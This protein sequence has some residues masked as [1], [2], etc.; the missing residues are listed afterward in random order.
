MSADITSNPKVRV[1]QHWGPHPLPGGRHR[2]QLWAPLEE[3][4]SLVLDGQELSMARSNDGWHRAEAHGRFGSTYAFELGDGRLVCDPASRQQA[5]P[6]DG[7][8][9]LTDSDS[10]GWVNASW[11]GRP[12]EEAVIYEIH[13][14]T[15][16]EKG[17]F[18][19]AV[20]KLPRLAEL[21]FTAIEVMP[22]AHFPGKRGWGYDGVLQYAPHSAYGS[23]DDFKAFIDAAH[24]LGMMVF[25][26]VVYNHFGPEGNYL[27][28]YAPGFF[29]QGASTPWGDAIAY[30]KPEVRSYFVEN[31]LYWLGEF[32][33]DGLR[34]DAI[35][36][37]E[38]CSDMHILEQIA[39][40]VRREI[41]G[42]HVH[43]MTE[44]PANG[45]D[46]MVDQPG[47]RFYRADWN[48]D[49]HHALHVAVT[50]EGVG[51]YEPFKDDPWGKLRHALAYG[52]LKPG[53]P[54]V[55]DDPPPTESL[56][57]TAFIHFL[58]NHDQV[59][60]RA[61]GDRLHLGIDRHVYRA[62]TEVLLLSPQIPLLFM[63]DDH[64]SLRPFHF[65]ADYN[66]EIA[67]AVREKRP[68]EA[69]NFGGFPKA[70][71]EAYVPDPN[72]PGSFLASKLDWREAETVGARAWADHVRRLIRV[73]R[74]KIV[75]LLKASTGYSGRVIDGPERCVYIDW[76]LD[77]QTL[78]LR[79]NF[80]DNDLAL[81]TGLGVRIFPDNEVESAHLGKAT[82]Q[83]FIRS[84]QI[85]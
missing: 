31:V 53:K 48:D 13:V 24:G 70:S 25:L 27:G 17:T 77:A 67:D 57:P 18:Q 32:R 15:F 80:S 73:R 36:Q 6:L 29:R 43:L 5:G 9:I 50:G 83:I 37:I 42:R 21:G 81:P 74:Q 56:P 40:T 61:L 65:F 11:K 62:V 63:G 2:F 55:S 33:L 35:D 45:T 78:R 7:P 47:G 71:S 38:D 84:I 72:D 49:F 51:Y 14:G 39:R 12:W 82:V 20:E 79:A 76:E 26:D 22:L 69:A 59:G 28:R 10:Y 85:V 3:K 4:V 44:N 30:E 8:S 1:S 64:L 68:K 60:N 41:V 19:A 54:I 75:P 34:F 52:Y 23:P 58:Q 66:G 46:L 16:T